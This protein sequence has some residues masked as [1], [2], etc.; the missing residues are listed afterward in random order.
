MKPLD[1]PSTIE[2]DPRA[3][4]LLRLWAAHGKLKV[5]INIGIHE[6]T[7]IDEAQAWGTILSDCAHHVSRALQQRYGIPIENSMRTII[8]AFMTETANPSTE[9]SGE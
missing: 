9:F 3:T 7:N 8:E 2:G 5:S 6:A 4:E 1:P